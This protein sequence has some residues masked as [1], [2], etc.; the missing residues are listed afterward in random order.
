[1]WKQRYWKVVTAIGHGQPFRFCSSRE[2]GVAHI[3]L[4]LRRADSVDFLR[5][6]R[7]GAHQ[8]RHVSRGRALEPLASDLQ[9]LLVDSAVAGCTRVTRKSSAKEG[10]GHVSKPVEF[11]GA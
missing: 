5:E 8:L 9:R 6:Q 10:H 11:V 2:L 3:E 7:Y 1:M 4:T